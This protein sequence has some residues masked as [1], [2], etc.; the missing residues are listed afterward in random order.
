MQDVNWWLMALAFLLGLVLSLALMIRRVKRE[1]PEYATLAAGAA[2]AVGAAKL[3]GGRGSVDVD[4][5]DSAT[6]RVPKIDADADTSAAKPERLRP[7]PR[8][9]GR[10]AERRQRSSP[11]RPRTR[12]PRSRP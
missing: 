9:P 3:K 4:A 10:Q 7:V 1:V 8:R 5:D 12:Q 2:G 11:I 6:L